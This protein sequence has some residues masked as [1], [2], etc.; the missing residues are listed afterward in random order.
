MASD[1]KVKITSIKKIITVESEE[2]YQITFK[3]DFLICST[4]KI[5]IDLYD[6][7]KGLLDLL[8]GDASNPIEDYIKEEFEIDFKRLQTQ[9]NDFEVLDND[10]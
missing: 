1:F 2:K 7:P 9:L 8:F 4:M 3:G 5:I 10:R 6:D